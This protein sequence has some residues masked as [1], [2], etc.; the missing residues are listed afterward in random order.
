[1]RFPVSVVG[2]ESAE[3]CKSGETERDKLGYER[4]KGG[5]TRKRG[6]GEEEILEQEEWRKWRK[7]I[8]RKGSGR[9]MD[10][11]E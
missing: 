3:L 8:R 2:A 4:E 5:R 9:K 7:T 6:N 1:V 11:E 10:K